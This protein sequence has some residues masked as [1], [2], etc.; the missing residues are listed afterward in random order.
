MA[1]QRA[2][3]LKEPPVVGRYY[4]VPSILWD[5][6][7]S[8]YGRK[9]REHL[10]AIQESSGATWW[11]VWGIKHE[12]TEHFNFPYLHYH[13]DPRF[14]TRRQWAHFKNRRLSPLG[15]VQ[16]SPLNHSELLGG[17]PKPVLRRKRCTSAHSE[18]E[19]CDAVSVTSL[20]RAFKDTICRSGKRGL[21]CP[22][23]QF[24]L[25]TVEVRDGV[26]TCPL[27][28]LRIDAATGRC[29]GPKEQAAELPSVHT[30][31]VPA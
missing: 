5:R 26:V 12:D 14:L 17:P 24:P 31:V 8:G 18:W 11:P 13:I 4:L 29:L 30:E 2:D 6:E 21:V 27:H 3:R 23:R 22:H 15:A 10:R 7:Y 28:G 9:V 25:G 19:H 16:G 20:N 1:M